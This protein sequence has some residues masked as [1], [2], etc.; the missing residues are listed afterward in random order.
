VALATPAA[1]LNSVQR[2]QIR[3]LAVSLEELGHI[4]NV[5]GDPGCL[6][7]YQEALGLYERIGG[8][9]E[10]ANLTHSLGNAYLEVPGLRDLD[11]AEQWFQRSLRLSAG[12]DRLGQAASLGQL[13]AV[14]VG[15]FEDARA[16]GEAGPVLLEHLNA[17]LRYC[18]QAL[19]LTPAD[20]HQSRA[21]VE[22][23]LGVVYA[24]AGDVGQALRHF[25]Q[26]LQHKEASGDIYAAGETR[27]NI[28]LLLAGDGRVTDALS[29][30][31]AALDNFQQAGPGAAAAAA[32]TERLIAGL[33]QRSP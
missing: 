22:N 26:S 28:A 21:T 24:R 3:E 2:H 19:S 29:Y 6:P 8:R 33:Q 25:Q 31:R 12:S 16:A 32:D 23:Q 18:Q 14:A 1:S 11:Q 9:Q 20:D 27:Y 7:Y 30:A 5:Q 4:L 17:A 13:G 10:E 15:R